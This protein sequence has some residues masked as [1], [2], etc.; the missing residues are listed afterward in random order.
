MK[1]IKNQNDSTQIKR[2]TNKEAAEAVKT[3][4]W[5]YCSKSEWKKQK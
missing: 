4:K 2:V 5:Y 1:C 3:G